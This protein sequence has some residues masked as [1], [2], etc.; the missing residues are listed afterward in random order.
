MERLSVTQFIDRCP[1]RDRVERWGEL[2][3]DRV[4]IGIPVE[5]PTAAIGML[6]HVGELATGVVGTNVAN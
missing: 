1:T 2:G 6:D 4:V 3:V 5:D